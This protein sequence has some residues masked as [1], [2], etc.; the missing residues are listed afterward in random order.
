MKKELT[1]SIVCDDNIKQNSPV[2]RNRKKW[3]RLEENGERWSGAVLTVDSPSVETSLLVVGLCYDNDKLGKFKKEKKR[4]SK[5]RWCHV[6]VHKI[7]YGHPVQFFFP[8]L[9]LLW[10]EC[11]LFPI[12]CIFRRWVQ[13]YSQRK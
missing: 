11:H 3:E 9:L 12:V 6:V 1:L 5:E 2:K 7:H 10:V 4:K 13:N 8:S